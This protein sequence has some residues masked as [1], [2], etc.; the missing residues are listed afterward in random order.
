MPTP[1]CRTD[2]AGENTNDQVFP[3]GI[4]ENADGSGGHLIVQI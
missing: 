4:A 3:L 1:T 2:T